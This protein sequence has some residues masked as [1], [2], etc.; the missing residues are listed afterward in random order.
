MIYLISQ[1]TFIFLTQIYYNMNFITFSSN[2]MTRFLW[3]FKINLRRLLLEDK[4]LAHEK[5]IFLNMPAKPIIR[6]RSFVKMQGNLWKIS[7]S[8]QTLLKILVFHNFFQIFR[9]TVFQ[10]KQF[11]KNKQKVP[12]ILTFMNSKL[13]DDWQISDKQYHL[14][15]KTK[16]CEISNT[17]IYVGEDL[18]FIIHVFYWCIQLDHEI[19]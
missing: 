11:S 13:P 12:I 8:L 1:V 2:F 9:T 16:S 15:Q 4:C 5:W 7:C 19:Y 14:V 10:E 17:D 6:V 18:E 3:Y